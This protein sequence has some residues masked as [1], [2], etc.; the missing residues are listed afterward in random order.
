MDNSLFS[1]NKKIK[2]DVVSTPMNQSIKIHLFENDTIPEGMHLRISGTTLP[3]NGV[4]NGIDLNNGVV[5]YS[6][7][8]DFIGSD[9]FTYAVNY[10]EEGEQK[11]FVRV[12]VL[13]PKG[14]MPLRTHP[15][16]ASTMEGKLISLNVFLNDGFN[17]SDA[18]RITAISKTNNGASQIYDAEEGTIVYAPFKSFHGYEYFTYTAT[19]KDG[20]KHVE[21]ISIHVEPEELIL[22]SVDQAEENVGDAVQKAPSEMYNITELDED[23]VNVKDRPAIAL[24]QVYFDFDQVYVRADARQTMDKN[25]ALLKEYPKAVIQVVSHCDSRGPK[26]YNMILSARRAKSTV[27]YLVQQGIG[28]DR[29]V[30]SVGVGE[31]NLVNDCGDGVPCSKADHQMNRRSELI[32]VG[33]LR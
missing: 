31:D 13:G 25:I 6:P 33:S 24:E 2:D 30:A 9:M 12:H 4:L 10:P 29:I 26:A 3:V 15:D 32:V 20:S 21:A 17:E 28:K 18:P 27:D 22:A 8:E 11:A 19:L 5:I 23:K 1:L 14:A 16:F 7:A